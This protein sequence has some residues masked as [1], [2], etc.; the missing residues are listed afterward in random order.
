MWNLEWS[1][2]KFLYKKQ[3]NTTWSDSDIKQD[4]IKFDTA[5]LHSNWSNLW[6]N[7]LNKIPIDIKALSC[8]QK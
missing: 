5:L 4:M 8:G 7:Y 1:N 3:Q 2:V 6:Q